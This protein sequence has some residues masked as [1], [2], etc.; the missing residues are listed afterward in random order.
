MCECNCASDQV[1]YWFPGP[2]GTV[3]GIQVDPGC[4][5]CQ[6]PAVKAGVRIFQITE[7]DWPHY[8][9]N[10]TPRLQF[11]PD[12]HGRFVPVI[13]AHYLLRELVGFAGDGNAWE[14]YIDVDTHLGNVD[15]LLGDALA[16]WA[17]SDAVAATHNHTVRREREAIEDSD[18]A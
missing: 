4:H 13:S 3:Y 16:G 1:D 7:N 14:Q 5:N 10:D 18:P 9:D 15:G 8:G 11:S 12:E 2:H 17:L 6:R